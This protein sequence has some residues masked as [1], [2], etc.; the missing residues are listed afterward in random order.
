MTVTLSDGS[1]VTADYAICT[2]SLGVLQ[3][4]VVTFEPPLPAWK[5]AG[6]E[7]MEMGTYT[8]IF[9]QFPPEADG[10][11]FWEHG[12][13]AGTEY[14]LYADPV[15]RGWYPVWQ[16]LTAPGF[17][18]G[19]GIFFVTVVYSQ[20]Y[21]AEQQ[22][23][24]TTKGEVIAV[25]R[26]MFGQEIPDPV[27]FMYPRWS[28]EPWSFGSFSNWPPGLSLETHQNLRANLERLWFAGEA[29]SVGYFGWLQGMFLFLLRSIFSLPVFVSWILSSIESGE[30]DTYTLT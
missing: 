14:F 7:G 18:P 6:I 29:T 19:S 20:S 22:D 21:I 9:L 1:C 11:F 28:L 10:S 17:I 23:D 24:E 27:D 30:S 15:G 5:Q 4:D 26:S 2:F 16:S 8:K 12:P 25:L 13:N 3:N